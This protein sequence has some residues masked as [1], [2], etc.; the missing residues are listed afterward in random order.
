M[1]SLLDFFT[2][3][4]NY[5]GQ[6]LPNSPEAASQGYAPN[7]FDRFGTGLD[8]LQQYPGLPAMPMDEEE[9]RRQRLLTL[10]QLGSTVARGGTLA[11]GLQS[12]QQQGLQRQLFQAQIGEQ[13]R[14][15]IEQ[16]AAR[17]ALQNIPGLTDVQKALVQ[18]L[19]PK[20]A[21]E[22]IAKQTEQEYGQTPQQVVVGGVPALAVFSKKGDMKV[23][24]ATPPP[25]TTSIDAGN[26]YLIRDSV[27]GTIVQR[28]P[29]SMTPGEQARLGVDLRRVGL[30]QERVGIEQRRLGLEGLRVGMDRERLA[31]AQQE[32]ARAGFELKETDAGFQLIPRMPGAAA[33]PITSA[34]GEPVKGV[35]GTKATEGQLNAAGYASRMIE[36]EKIIDTA[37]PQAQRVGPL[38]ATVGALPLVGGVGER[39]MM[40]PEQQQVRQAQEDWVRS[41]LRKESG[42]V[43]GDEEMSREIKTYFPQIGDSPP[44]IAQ[45]ARARQIA[46]NAMQTSAGPAMFQV[47]TAPPP[48]KAP[49]PAGQKRYR[50]ENGRLVEY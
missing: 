23:L 14:K 31:I 7:I 25:N 20:E 5:G 26:E 39:L 21:A 42:A 44:V 30:E 38:A 27:T 13:Q 28:I 45:K 12:V 15:L 1:A 33:V 37:P 34:T 24:N 4:G 49:A 48:A 19:P 29:K 6:Q 3:S 40:T 32:A 43:I 18:S 11:E 46:I 50:Y 10:A 17:Q 9:R 22:F 8:R 35:S 2:G 47:M 16:Q 36:A 41:K